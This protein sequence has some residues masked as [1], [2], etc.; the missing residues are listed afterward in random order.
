[1][2][3]CN[4]IW[5]TG[6]IDLSNKKPVCHSYILINCIYFVLNLIISFYNNKFKFQGTEYS[7]VHTFILY[8]VEYFVVTTNKL[9]RLL[10]RKRA[11]VY[12]QGHPLR[13]V[14]CVT[15]LER[16]GSSASRSVHAIHYFSKCD[17]SNYPVI[18]DSRISREDTHK[19]IIVRRFDSSNGDMIYV[20]IYYNSVYTNLCIVCSYSLAISSFHFL[21]VYCI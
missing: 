20:T 15:R 21:A 13:L 1:M 7:R 19:I 14:I 8:Y 17:Y 2:K 18:I 6:S 3:A 12:R 9:S 4:R 10:R 16:V 11:I 5:T